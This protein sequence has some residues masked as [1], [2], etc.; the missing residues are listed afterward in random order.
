MSLD[1]SVSIVTRLSAEGRETTSI[2]GMGYGFFSSIHI[3]SG[4]HPAYC[5]TCTETYFSGGVVRL[6]RH[7][8]NLR[9][10]EVKG[11]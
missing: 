3:G 6:L 2:P 5:A 11:K 4:S 10:G 9:E 1:S 8:A 7:G